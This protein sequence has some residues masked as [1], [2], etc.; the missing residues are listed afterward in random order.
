MSVLSK[1]EI[2]VRLATARAVDAAGGG[3]RAAAALGCNE[4]KVS[5]LQNIEN[6]AGAQAARRHLKASEVVVLD[7]LA[8]A[9][10]ILE[11][12][13]DAAGYRLAPKVEQGVAAEGVIQHLSGITKEVSEALAVMADASRKSTP[14][15][16]DARRIHSELQDVID[17]AKEAQA[18]MARH[19]AGEKS[20]LKLA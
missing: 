17:R 20:N 12:I 4:G 6:T 1:T 19:L 3:A 15:V 8:G 10:F 18:E 13:A 9:P 11:A 16:T 2:A 14:S 7:G 5:L